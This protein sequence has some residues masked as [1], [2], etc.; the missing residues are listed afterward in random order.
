MNCLYLL[1]PQFVTPFS[2]TTAVCTGFLFGKGFSTT[3]FAGEVL[4][5]LIL[6]IGGLVS[7]LIPKSSVFMADE[8][9]RARESNAPKKNMFL[10]MVSARLISMREDWELHQQR[11]RLTDA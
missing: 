10:K 8:L 11:T 5:V 2:A 3:F 4:Y 9:G 6:L 1:S 7:G